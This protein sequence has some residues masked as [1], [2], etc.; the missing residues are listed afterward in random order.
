MVTL[1][2]EINV[3]EMW[4]DGVGVIGTTAGLGKPKTKGKGLFRPDA[5][6]S[7]INGTDL[8]MNWTVIVQRRV[9]LSG[10]KTFCQ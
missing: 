7:P 9:C 2:E 1:Y 10:N 8:I 6:N 5:L 3:A 4:K